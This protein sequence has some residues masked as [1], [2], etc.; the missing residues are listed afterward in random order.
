[1]VN[2]NETKVQPGATILDLRDGDQVQMC[3]F[4]TCSEDGRDDG[5]AFVI[6]V[7]SAETIE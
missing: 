6:L 7:V 4:T 1:M 2:G 3:S 5:V